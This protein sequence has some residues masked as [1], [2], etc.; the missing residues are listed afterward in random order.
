MQVEPLVDDGRGARDALIAGHMNLARSL[1]RRFGG[2][3]EERADL[4]QVALTGLVLAAERFE[5][6]RGVAFSSF[7]TV[8]V[9][10][11][12]KRYFRD[13]AW[14]MRVPR[15]VQ[16]RYL[17]VKEASETLTHTLG[18][19]PTVDQI[20]AFL[21]ISAE[22]VLEAMEAGTN[23]WPASL[24]AP[25]LNDDGPV[26]EIPVED[27]GFDRTLEIREL[28]EQLSGLSETE[29]IVLSGLYFRDCTQR[30]LAAELGISQMQVSRIH[31]ATIHKLRSLL[32]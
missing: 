4:E 18:S 20:A 15:S 19:S 25:A 12:L 8:T 13:K 5:A 24:G 11:E 30:Q 9:L 31:A 23:F 21:H 1:A 16:E 7:A 22:H 29:R 26:A 17:T 28:S 10:G 14:G 32:R 6:D 2:R 27:E 3:R